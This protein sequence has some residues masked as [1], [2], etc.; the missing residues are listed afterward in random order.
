MPA[1]TVVYTIDVSLFNLLKN[2]KPSP[3]SESSEAFS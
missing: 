2:S 1:T 3:N